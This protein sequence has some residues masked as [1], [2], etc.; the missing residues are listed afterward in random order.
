[1][2]MTDYLEEQMGTHLFRT[3]TYVKPTTLYMLLFTTLPTTGAAIDGVE[4]AAASYDRVPYGPSDA[5]WAA[6]VGGNGEFYNLF[7]IIFPTPQENWGTIVG[8]GLA[9]ADLATGGNLL[10]FSALASNKNV[11]NGAPAPEFNPG[12][13]KFTLS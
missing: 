5:A 7:S 1:M 2:G 13:V 8:W 12:A 9:D 11:P 4:C 6:P 3:G 10:I